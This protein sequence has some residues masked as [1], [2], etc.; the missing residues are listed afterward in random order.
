MYQL[1]K[2]PL[3]NIIM[4]KRYKQDSEHASAPKAA[5]IC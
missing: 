5:T 2:S 4:V 3:S 1:G